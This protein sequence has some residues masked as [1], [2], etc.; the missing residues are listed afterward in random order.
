MS[1]GW[2]RSGKTSRSKV[3]CWA[4]T[5]AI[6]RQPCAPFSPLARNGLSTHADEIPLA[7]FL[8]FLRFYS[9][10]RRDAWAFS[11]LPGDGGSEVTEPLA[12]RVKSLGGE[13]RLG[14]GLKGW[15]VGK[16][17]GLSIA[18]KNRSLRR[19]SF[20]RWI[21]RRRPP[22]SKTALAKTTCTFRAA[23]RMRLCVCGLTARRTPGRKAACLPVIL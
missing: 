2:T 13:I 9:I 19:M 6:G 3:T 22:L 14:N 23:C 15:R 1:V 4:S 12:E 5:S 21:L 16:M 8:A 7:G 18:V 10:L 20:W 17:A 11:Y